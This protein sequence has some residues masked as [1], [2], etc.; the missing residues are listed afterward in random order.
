MSILGGLRD[1]LAHLAFEQAL[2]E[3]RDLQLTRMLTG[4]PLKEH[5]LQQLEREAALGAARALY[6]DEVVLAWG[7]AQQ[8]GERNHRQDY[9]QRGTASADMAVLATHRQICQLPIVGDPQWEP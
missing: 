2:R 9:A 4:H 8:S 6:S 1:T 5:Q 7:L 3:V